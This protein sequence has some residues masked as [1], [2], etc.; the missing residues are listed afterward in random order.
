MVSLVSC[1]CA[2][3]WYLHIVDPFGVAVIVMRGGEWTNIMAL[4]IIIPGNDFNV[5]WSERQD[6]H[7]AVVPKEIR[8]KHPVFAVRYFGSVMSGEPS[9][10]GC[11]SNCKYPRY[12]KAYTTYVQCKASQ[13]VCLCRPDR[14]HLPSRCS[15]L[16]ELYCDHCWATRSSSM[17]H[18]QTQRWKP[19]SSER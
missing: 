18:Q 1:G 5:L 9:R 13:R 3:R 8:R 17:L 11:K 15:P 10:D 16:L 2:S 7:P 6:V 12:R 19:G 4:A 14:Q